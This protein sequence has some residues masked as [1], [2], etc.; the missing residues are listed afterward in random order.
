MKLTKKYILPF[1]L[2][3]CASSALTSCDDLEKYTMDEIVAAPSEKFN[4]TIQ[5]VTRLDSKTLFGSEADFSTVE[6]YMVR[7]LNKKEGAWLTIL[8]RADGASVSNVAKLSNTSSHWTAFAFNQM[9][10]SVAQGSYLLFNQ[11]T[12][13]IYGLPCGEGCY[14][15][16]IVP[17]MQ[18]TRTDKDE[19]G[20]VSGVF[21]V[22]FQ[23]NYRTVRFDTQEQLNAFG[24]KEG[25]MSQMKKGA[26]NMLVVGTIKNSLIDALAE[27]VASADPSFRVT[28]VAT[29]AEYSIFMLSE[30][31]FWGFTSVNK[32]ALGN[33]IDS[34]EINV[35]W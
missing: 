18:G 35:M 23:I 15:T 5:Y 24:G 14:M 19:A 9:Q 32:V 1:V 16:G 27:S 31:R 7:T 30:H 29:G 4:A 6:N 21:P 2:F 8:D 20:E 22:R 34:Y 10:S 12:R 25:V 17:M 28:S 11:P 3:A 13:Q 26:M 33:G